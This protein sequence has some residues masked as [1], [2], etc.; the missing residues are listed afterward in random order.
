[1]KVAVI[2]AGV[3]GLLAAYRLAP[4]HQVSLFEAGSYPGGHT[5]TVDV[6]VDGHALS[7]DTGFIVYN[8]RTYPNFCGLIDELGVPWVDTVMSFGAHCPQSGFEYGT[9]GLLG[10]IARPANLVDRRLYVLLRDI[11]KFFRVAK[12]ELAECPERLA[13]LTLAEFVAEADLSDTF[14]EF[15]I[16]PMTAAVWSA[17]AS[18]ALQF[19]ALTLLRFLDNHGLLSASEAPV[20]RTNRWRLP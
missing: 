3:S 4:E 10:W 9:E 18:T 16:V 20:W 5:N 6:E 15:Y 13:E 2:G 12:R 8:P 14:R 11:F 17:P 1:M 7:V 19:P